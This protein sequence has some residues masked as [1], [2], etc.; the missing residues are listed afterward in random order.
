MEEQELTLDLGRYAPAEL[1]L[2]RG[3]LWDETSA[4]INELDEQLKADS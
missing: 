1:T 2:Q 4:V 3:N